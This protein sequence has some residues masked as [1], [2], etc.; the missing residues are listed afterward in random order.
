LRVIQ[1]E[2]AYTVIWY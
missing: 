1:E 2:R